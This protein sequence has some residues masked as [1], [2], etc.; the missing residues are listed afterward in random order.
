MSTTTE[1]KLC[2]WCAAGETIIHENKGT[3]TGRGYGEPVSVEVRHWCPEEA[4]QPSRMITRIGRD[5]ESAIAAWNRRTAAQGEGRE[6]E[7]AFGNGRRVGLI[8][9]AQAVKDRAVADEIFVSNAVQAIM[10]LVDPAPTAQTEGE[11][12]K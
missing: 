8:E 7:F 1:L 12:P 10:V 2:P 3:W 5:R 4:G 6:H 9:A 11:Q